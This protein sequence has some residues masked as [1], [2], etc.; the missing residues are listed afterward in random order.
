[1]SGSPPQTTSVN[2]HHVY[3]HLRPCLSF[4]R[5][6]KQMSSPVYRL[7]MIRSDLA[8]ERVSQVKPR[9]DLGGFGIFT[10]RVRST[11]GR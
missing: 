8:M 11:T 2:T 6:N 3:V 9:G 1:M 5:E 7:A 10:A 4:W